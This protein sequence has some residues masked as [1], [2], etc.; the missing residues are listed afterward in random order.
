EFM[1]RYENMILDQVDLWHGWIERSQG[2]RILN[3]IHF[4]ADTYG[5]VIHDADEKRALAGITAIMTLWA[6]SEYGVSSVYQPAKRK[7]KR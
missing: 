3:Y 7:P 4:V 6:A 2:K 5:L 1:R